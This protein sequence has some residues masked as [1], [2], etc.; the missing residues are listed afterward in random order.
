MLK[1]EKMEKAHDL[2]SLS[3]NPLAILIVRNV[4]ECHVWSVLGTWC[5]HTMVSCESEGNSVPN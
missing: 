1:T 4:L 2:Q 3:G 5:A